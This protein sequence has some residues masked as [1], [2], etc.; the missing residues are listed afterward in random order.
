MLAFHL[1]TTVDKEPFIIPQ[2]TSL[3]WFFVHILFFHWKG[4]N[5]AGT[6]ANLAVHLDAGSVALE[7]MF[8]DGEA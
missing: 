2:K 1:P 7:G 5:H 4:D 8:D 3:S 6:L